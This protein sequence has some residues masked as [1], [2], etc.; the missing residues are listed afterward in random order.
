VELEQRYSTDEE[1]R[2]KARAVALEAARKLHEDYHVGGVGVIGD[3]IHPELPW[4]F[5]SEISLV[6]WDVPKIVNLW[7]LGRNVGGEFKLPPPAG[8]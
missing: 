2:Q 1:R 5:W 6:V 4:N 7:D 8:S 3:L